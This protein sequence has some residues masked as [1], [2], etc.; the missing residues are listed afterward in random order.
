[1]GERAQEL[2]PLV[3]VVDLDTPESRRQVLATLRSL[4]LARGVANRRFVTRD[5]RVLCEQTGK[6]LKI[7]RATCR[8]VLGEDI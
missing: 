2:S 8:D 3:R 1:M 6:D 5:G 7:D 4:L